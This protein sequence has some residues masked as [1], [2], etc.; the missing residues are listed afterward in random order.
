MSN[1]APPESPPPRH[2]FQF[3]LGTLLLIT[4]LFAVLAAAFAGMLDRR[5]GRSSMPPGFFV[6]MAV[7]APVAVLIVLSLVRAIVHWL[8]GRR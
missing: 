3:G 6:L 8:Q 4:T 7:A 5:A 1:S 2:P